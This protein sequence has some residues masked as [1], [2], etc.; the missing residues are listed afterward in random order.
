MNR[1][2]DRK[3]Y[4]HIYEFKKK[5]FSIHNAQW[6]HIKK[7]MYTKKCVNIAIY[8]FSFKEKLKIAHIEMKIICLY[9][10]VSLSRYIIVCE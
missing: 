4:I 1:K 2:R 7:K 6:A 5:L 9:K 10:Y 8:E 3:V